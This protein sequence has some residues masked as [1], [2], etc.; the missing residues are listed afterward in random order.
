MIKSAPTFVKV[1]Y[2]NLNH[3]VGLALVSVTDQQQ[4][5]VYLLFDSSASNFLRSV[6]F[7]MDTNYTL[8]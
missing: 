6:T 5:S 2:E 1:M 4:C 7:S 3:S 8:K